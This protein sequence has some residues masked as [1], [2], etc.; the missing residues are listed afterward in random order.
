MGSERGRG[1]CCSRSE[2][3]TYPSQHCGLHPSPHPPQGY[4]AKSRSMTQNGVLQ[5]IHASS[6]GTRTRRCS[7]SEQPTRPS[8]HCGLHPSPHPPQVRALHELAPLDKE[9]GTSLSRGSGGGGIRTREALWACRFSR[10]VVSSAHPPLRASIIPCVM[11]A[12]IRS[13]HELAWATCGLDCTANCAA[14]RKWFLRRAA[15]LHRTGRPAVP[16]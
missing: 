2:Q 12:Q 16:A 5:L 9:D 1:V 7:R 3:P 4:R 13:H 6:C 15:G 10:P 11:T 8:L 14:I